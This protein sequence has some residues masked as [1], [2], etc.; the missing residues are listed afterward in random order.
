[1]KPHKKTKQ[2]ESVASYHHRIKHHQ[3]IKCHAVCFKII[4]LMNASKKM[5]SEAKKKC[6]GGILFLAHTKLC[7][8]HM[9]T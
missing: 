8:L 2:K 9:N 5:K 7:W 1:M 3:V 4:I 6:R